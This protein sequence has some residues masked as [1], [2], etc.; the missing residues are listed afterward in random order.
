MGGHLE[1]LHRC[2]YL[3]PGYS[4]FSIEAFSVCFRATRGRDNIS[5]G[6]VLALIGPSSLHIPGSSYK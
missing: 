2:C 6:R 5:A 1:R 4:T 3:T